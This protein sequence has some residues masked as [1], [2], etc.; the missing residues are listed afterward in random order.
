LSPHVSPNRGGRIASSDSGFQRDAIP[1]ALRLESNTAPIHYPHH[2][3]N[4][5]LA[6]FEPLQYIS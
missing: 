6:I 5:E 3:K 1:L 4:G 2:W